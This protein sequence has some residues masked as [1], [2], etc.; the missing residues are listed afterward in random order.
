[1]NERLEIRVAGMGGQGMI[2]AG[3]L[4]A[5]AAIRD[6]K[7]AAATAG[8]P[9]QLQT[10]VITHFQ[11]LGD[12]RMRRGVRAVDQISPPSSF[13]E[14]LQALPIPAGRGPD[15]TSQGSSEIG[16][17]EPRE[18]GEHSAVVVAPG[19]RGGLHGADGADPRDAEL[20]KGVGQ[21][22]S[23]VREPADADAG[24]VALQ[25]GEGLHQPAEPGDRVDPD[26]AMQGGR[27]DPVVVFH[28]HRPA[29]PRAPMEA[30]GIRPGGP[31]SM[32]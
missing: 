24:E 25:R 16:V 8:N 7:N 21:L 18:R 17:A 12:S 23:L 19:E 2:L 14:F 6:G 22:G 26:E 15:Q 27:P 11:T 4:L 31:W 9:A 13:F 5:D 10:R 32:A 29:G 20:A 3:V 30:N 1:M 28:H